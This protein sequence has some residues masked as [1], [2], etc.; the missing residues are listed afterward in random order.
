MLG[1]GPGN[2]H[3]ATKSN[4]RFEI[5]RCGQKRKRTEIDAGLT[6]RRDR[7]DAEQAGRREPASAHARVER[8]AHQHRIHS[9][10]PRSCHRE[11]DHDVSR[12][13]RA[14]GRHTGRNQEDEKWQ[15]RAPVSNCCDQLLN[16]EVDGTVA[17]GDAEEV[18]DARDKDQ[19][20]DGKSG[21]DVPNRHARQPYAD[22]HGG[23]KH[24]DAEVN[25]AER[26]D[27]EHGDEDGDG[28]RRHWR[29]NL[30]RVGTELNR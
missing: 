15:Q 29:R 26:G 19:D 9:R 12:L 27:R 8:N 13:R 10:A 7:D 22:G 24:Q 16:C 11:R 17:L 18:G 1:P 2:I 25:A 20:V 6:G 5:S 4:A 23:G 14:H 3:A 30:I 28:K 21:Q